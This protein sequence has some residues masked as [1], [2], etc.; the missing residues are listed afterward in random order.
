MAKRPSV[1]G[2]A[3]RSGRQL[4]A[5]HRE[6]DRERVGRVGIA[7]RWRRKACGEHA[8][9]RRGVDRADLD[10][11]GIVER[12]PD[13]TPAPQRIGIERR[14]RDPDL[15]AAAWRQAAAIAGRAEA[16][17]A[18]RRQQSGR[19]L[20]DDRHQFTEEAGASRFGT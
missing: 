12:K 9:I 18:L 19:R 15:Q 8:L 11:A 17:K 10:V 7:A 4:A 3:A 5:A 6:V 16:A 14:G 20:E 13:L 1:D 2:I